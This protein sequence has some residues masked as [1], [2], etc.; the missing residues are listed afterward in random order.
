MILN[1]CVRFLLIMNLR[2]CLYNQGYR[3]PVQFLRWDYR[4][5]YKEN[6]VY[7]SVELDPNIVVACSGVLTRVPKIS[8]PD[9]GKLPN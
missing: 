7:K 8:L 4:N 1:A 9:I 6:H 3:R 2:L 5:S